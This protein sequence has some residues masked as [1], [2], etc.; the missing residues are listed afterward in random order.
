MPPPHSDKGGEREL[1]R[2]IIGPRFPAS[3]CAAHPGPIRITY[4]FTLRAF[5]PQRR[6]SPMKYQATKAFTLSGGAAILVL[7]IGFGGH[8]L[9]PSGTTTRGSST[10]APAFRPPMLPQDVSLSKHLEEVVARAVSGAGPMGRAHEGGP[11]CVTD[12][13]NPCPPVVDDSANWPSPPRTQTFCRP[14]GT[15]GQHCYRRLLP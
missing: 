7:A 3:D 1:S 12:S 2:N 11:P 15:F 14:A 13:T 5:S 10:I 9:S 8:E 6:R 4:G